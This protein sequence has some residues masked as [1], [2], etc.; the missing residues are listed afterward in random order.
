[1]RNATP[2]GGP[3]AADVG[4][5][6]GLRHELP[7]QASAPGLVHQGGRMRKGDSRCDLL[8]PA[9]IHQRPPNEITALMCEH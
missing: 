1:M 7:V 3:L 6:V 9:A 8:A 4:D 5:R 2:R